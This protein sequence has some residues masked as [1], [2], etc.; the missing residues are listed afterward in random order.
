MLGGLWEF[1]GGKI[2]PSERASA[3]C[4]R[5]IREEVGLRVDV[6]QRIARVRHVY[7]HL[8]VDI[9]VFHCRYLGGDVV[10]DGPTDHRWITI[11]ETAQYAFPKANHK[12]LPA[13]RAALGS[14]A[15]GGATPRPRRAKS[16]ADR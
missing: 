2:G 1:P 5:E 11:E 6:G 9:D 10:L 4:A 16:R 14:P 13:V 15:A 12:F 8:V 7:T 3:A